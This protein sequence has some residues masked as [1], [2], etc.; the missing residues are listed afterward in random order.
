[1]PHR[2]TGSIAGNRWPASEPL[3]QAATR[4]GRLVLAGGEGRTGKTALVIGF[5]RGAGSQPD[6]YAVDTMITNGFVTIVFS[7]VG[8]NSPA[9]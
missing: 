6:G 9:S 5:T 8:V 4:H 7:P 3:R 1:M 2:S